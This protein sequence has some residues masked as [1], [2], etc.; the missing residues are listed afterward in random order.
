MTASQAPALA[1]VHHLK[2]PVTDLARSLEWYR[3]RLGYLAEIEFVE[4]GELMGC[5]MAHPNGG[6]WLALRLDPERAKAVAGFDYFGIGVHGKQ[7][8]DDLAARLTAQGENHGGVHRAGIGWVLSGLLD[9]D[10][11]DIR[12]YTIEQHTRPD[13]GTVTVIGDSREQP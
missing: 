9:P 1:G 2:L 11:H 5:A 10:G 13:P 8:I 6:P 7:E 12:F 3:S 4:R